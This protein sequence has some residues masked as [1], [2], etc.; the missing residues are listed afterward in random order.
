[1]S[2]GQA[3]RIA[4]ARVFLKNAPILLMDEPTSALDP[5]L[6][7]ALTEATRRLYRGRTAL[8]I[9][10]RLATIRTADRVVV[11]DQGRLV[12]SGSPAELM[13]LNGA[14]RRL[15]EPAGGRSA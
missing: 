11:L 9:A 12:E 8:V 1:V 14:Y 10:H 15:V 5:N 7:E 4:I 3:Q 13:A 2:G 6:E